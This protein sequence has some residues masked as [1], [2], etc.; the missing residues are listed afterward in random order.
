M[1][2]AVNRRLMGDAGIAVCLLSL[3][4]QHEKT[5][6][7]REI[8]TIYANYRNAV[9]NNFGHAARENLKSEFNYFYKPSAYF[10]FGRFDLAVISL[11]DDFD[12]SSRTFHPFDPMLDVGNKP[13]FENFFCRVITGPTPCLDPQTNI[14]TRAR[15]TF[16]A[17]PRK[18]L[19]AMTV[20]KVSNGLL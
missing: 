16:L 13:Y 8:Q 9:R 12:F 14:V 4:F 7:D 10:L 11:I 3:P 2:D 20:L 15:Q 1:T 19:F 18:P 6:Y 5:F 17:E